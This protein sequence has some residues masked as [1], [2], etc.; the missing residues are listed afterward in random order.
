MENSDTDVRS[1]MEKG[2]SNPSRHYLPLIRASNGWI[3]K[4]LFRI[5]FGEGIVP[6]V[7]PLGPWLELKRVHFVQHTRRI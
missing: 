4:S 1:Y 2:D 6:A 3:N 5:V 7:L